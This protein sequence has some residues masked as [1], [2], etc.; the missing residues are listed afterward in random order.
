ME[1]RSVVP[2][3][4]LVEEFMM[5]WACAVEHHVYYNPEYV[6]ALRTPAFKY[7]SRK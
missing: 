4:K 5:I 3:E 7:T 2:F 6:P 1:G